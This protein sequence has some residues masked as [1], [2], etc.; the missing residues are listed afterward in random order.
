[1]DVGNSFG[2]PQLT[3]DNLVGALRRAGRRLALLGDDTWLALFPRSAFAI[4]HPFPSFNVADLH[5]V[6]DGVT[7]TLEPLLANH[8]AHKHASS[9]AK[10]SS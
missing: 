9:L 8:G 5:T 10:I 2:A 1:M 6:D 4:A 7:A 3:E